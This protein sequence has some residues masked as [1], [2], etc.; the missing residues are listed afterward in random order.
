VR[1][2][3]DIFQ[4]ALSNVERYPFT[5]QEELASINAE[6][7]RMKVKKCRK[8]KRDFNWGL[9]DREMKVVVA[10]YIVSD[11]RLEIAEAVGRMLCQEKKCVRAATLA[12]NPVPVRDWF[13]TISLDDAAAMNDPVNRA[14][15]N[16]RSEAL[17]WVAQ[18]KSVHWVRDQNYDRSVAPASESVA[19][20]FADEMHAL[21]EGA[22][23]QRL[24]NSTD[25]VSKNGKRSARR[26]C[27]RF[28]KRWQLSR[29]HL[30][31]RDAEPKALLGTKAGFSWLCSERS[32]F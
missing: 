2:Y 5:L 20:R 18:V 21:G 10:S 30:A 29:S 25:S 8:Q 31:C 26:W 7:K 22:A 23:T 17:K 3:A 32:L 19:R 11:Y 27:S 28:R 15:M 1:H 14:E 16:I 12:S 9:T 4:S 6:L 13:L 24:L